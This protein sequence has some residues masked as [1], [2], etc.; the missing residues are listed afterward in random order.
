MDMDGWMDSKR[1]EWR[2]LYLY[3]SWINEMMA[4]VVRNGGANQKR[5]ET[6][7][8]AFR[9][10]DLSLVVCPYPDLVG[11]FFCWNGHLKSASR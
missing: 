10:L 9:G 3:V 2:L 7:L 1:K 5:F 6:S 4:I 11:H 8:V